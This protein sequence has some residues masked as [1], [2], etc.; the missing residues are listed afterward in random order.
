MSQNYTIVFNQLREFI[1]NISGLDISQVDLDSNFIELGLDSLMMVRLNQKILKE[2][3]IEMTMLQF[4]EDTNTL[5]KIIHFLAQ[6]MPTHEAQLNNQFDKQPIHAPQPVIPVH[7]PKIPHTAIEALMFNQMQ[8]MSQLMSQQL[9]LL[10]H[11]SVKEK[12][13]PTIS[14]KQPKPQGMANVNLR[15]MKLEPDPLTSQQQQFLETFINRYIQRSKQSRAFIQ[16]YRPFLSDW[17]NSLGFRLSLKEIMYPVVGPKSEGSKFWDVDGN[18]YIDIACG[19]GVSFLGNRPPFVIQ[20]IEKQLHEGFELGPQSHVVGEV[21]Q[22]VCELTGAE[23][24]AFCN[25]GSESVMF[26]IRIARAYTGKKLIVLFSGSYHG[27]SD[28]VLAAPGEDGKNIPAAPGTTDGMVQDV[29]IL[30]YGVPESLEIIQSHAHELAAVLVEPVQSRRPGFQPKE[31]LHDLRNI[32]QNK[33]IVLIF[34]EMITGFRIHPGGAQAWFGIKADLATYGKIVAGGMPIGVVAGKAQYMNLIDGGMWQFNDHSHPQ[35]E[36]I[37][38]AGTFC[39]HPLT[40]AAAKAALSFLK[41]QGPDLQN[42]V[43]KRTTYFAQTLN[44]FFEQNNV[45][46][47]IEYFGSLFRFESFG[48]YHQLLQPIEMDI[49]FYLLMEKGIYTWE[50]RVCFFSIAHTDDDIELIIAKVKETINDM[51]TGGFSL[52]GSLKEKKIAKDQPVHYPIHEAQKQLWFLARLNENAIPAYV[53]SLALELSGSLNHE[54][55]Q[56]AVQC[57]VDR[58]DSLR[59]IFEN[60]GE[61]QIVLPYVKV[62]IPLVDMSDQ[63]ALC[64]DDIAKWRSDHQ[65]IH[66]NLE[67]GPLFQF[68]FFKIEAEKYILVADFHHTVADGYSLLVLLKDLCQIYSAL[69]ENK[70]IAFPLPLQYSDFMDWQQSYF[71]SEKF[72]TDE[73]FWLSQFPNGLPTVDFPSDYPRPNSFTFHGARY[74]V[75]CDSQ[76]YKN[77]QALGLKRRCTSFMTMLAAYTLLLHRI[78]G[79]DEVIIGFPG[80]GRFFEGSEKLTGYCAHMVPFYSQLDYTQSFHDYLD[81]VRQRLL[82]VYDHQQYPFSSLIRKLNLPQ[83]M[84]RGAAISFEFNLDRFTQFPNMHGL[85]VTPYD[86]G[87]QYAKYDLILDVLDIGND[88]LLKFEYASDCFSENRIQ[89]LAGHYLSLLNA[90][91]DNPD[92]PVGSVSLLSEQQR[93]Q[94]LVEWNQTHRDI[95]FHKCFHELFENQVRQTPNVIAAVDHLTSI[96]YQDLNNRANGL[97][98]MLIEQNIGP[99]GLVAILA[100]R[101]IDFLIAILGVFKAGGAYIP[102]DPLHPSQRIY[103]V[104]KESQTSLVLAEKSFIAILTD[105]MSSLNDKPR[106]FILDEVLK[107]KHSENNPP[108]RCT[109]DHLA[110]VIYTSGSTGVPKGAMVEHKGM[111]NHLFAKVFELQLTSKDVVAQNASQCFDISVWQFLS[112]LLVGGKTHICSNDISHDPVLLLDQV[113]NH[114][115]TILEL[116]PSLLRMILDEIDSVGEKRPDLSGLRWLVP[117]GEALPPKLCAQWLTHYP[118]IPVLNAYGPTEC[119]DDVSHF[120]I[121]TP[122]GPKTTQIPIG[123][124]IINMQLYILDARLQPVPVGVVGELYVGGIGVGRGYLNNPKKTAEAFLKNPFSSDPNARLYKTG[125]LARF[126]TDGNIEF[127]GRIDHQVKVR[128]FRIELGEIE[129]VLCQHPQIR[130]TVVLARED[131]PGDQRLVA[132]VVPHSALQ[133]DTDIKSHE[134][135]TFLSEN[136]PEYMVPSHYIW[137]TEFKLTSNGKIDRKALPKPDNQDL[138]SD[139]PYHAPKNDIEK[140]LVLIWEDVLKRDKIGTRDNYFSLGGD[141][142]KSIQIVSRL[143]LA[144]LNLPIRDIF[145]YPTIA[146]LALRVTAIDRQIDQGIVTGNVP[147]TAI[148]TWFFQ[149]LG[150]QKNHYNQ[151]ICLDSKH[152]LQKHAVQAALES[153]QMH[154]DA[155]RMTFLTH[156]EGVGVVHG[157]DYPFAFDDIDLTNTQN[158]LAAYEKHANQLQASINFNHGPLMKSMLFHLP[159]RDRLLIVVHHLVMD[160]VSWQILLQDFFMAYENIVANTP[161]QLPLKTDS[162]KRWAE[163]IQ[164]FANSNAIMTEKP[165]WT[166]LDHIHVNPLPIDAS[167]TNSYQDLASESIVFSK[168]DTNCLLYHVNH[169]YNTEINDILLVSL[170]RTFHLWHGDKRTAIM[171]EGHGRENLFEQIDITR[172]IGWFTSEFPVILDLTSEDTGIQ[173]KTIKEMIRQIPNKGI[174]YGILKYLTRTEPVSFQLRPQ[175]AFNYLGQ[176]DDIANPLVELLP[177]ADKESISPELSRPYD[178]DIECMIIKGQL[179]VI[180]NY[181]KHHLNPDIANWL[182]SNFDTELRTIMDHCKNK[183]YSE[184]TPS[185]LTYSRLSLDELD[186]IISTLGI[187]K[188]NLQDMYSLSHMQEGMLFHK[189]YHQD[190]V[191]YFEQFS[192]TITGDLMI[193]L[194]EDTWNMLMKRYDILRTVFA[195]KGIPNPLQ[196]VLKEHP[197]EFMFH[198]IRELEKDPNAYVQ[199]FKQHDRLKGFD[200]SKDVLT[201]LS[202]FQVSDIH[203]HVVWSYHHIIMDGWCLG[204]LVKELLSSYQALQ[205]GHAPVLKPPMQYKT[206]IQWLQNQDSNKSK[207]FWENYLYGYT[208][209]ASLPKTPHH[210]DHDNEQSQITGSL[211]SEQ[212]TKRLHDFAVEAQV[213]P[214]SVI[215]TV[216]G[217]LL[218]HYNGVDD[219]VFGIAVSGRPTDIPEVEDIVGLFLNTVPLRVKA[220]KSQRFIDLVQT[221]QSDNLAS[222]PHHYYS[223]A[224]IQTHSELKQDLLDHVFIFQNFPLSEALY[225]LEQEF[226]LNFMMDD[227]DIFEQTSYDLSIEINPGEQL[228]IDLRYNTSLFQASYIKTISEQVVNTIERIIDNPDLTVGAIQKGFMTNEESREQAN[229]IATAMNIDEE[230]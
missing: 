35:G 212:Y 7:Q 182:L 9:D 6:H 122:P 223:L 203:Y 180:I 65:T 193:G 1:T 91:V 127:L 195:Y 137:M 58:H 79:S 99:D 125:D 62:E 179:Q 155:L 117:T 57:V 77:I 80:A 134:L 142:I 131:E 87:I 116:V 48:K 133:N 72:K 140:K 113:V 103:Q 169:A 220:M 23:R 166:S 205:M 96:T 64:A 123:R 209:L 165:Y 15:G 81:F 186:N 42:Q 39:K 187:E 27:N 145:L 224:D 90:L 154:H 108:I 219:V 174:G 56:K 146:E 147:L 4:Y 101:S 88:I 102:L 26:A 71:Q 121:S 92:M 78:T 150:L 132:Y 14:K 104:L 106:L 21:A 95:P 129:A 197:I 75:T 82:S 46:I 158:P 13:Q 50:K 45:A 44:Q 160:G 126:Q 120:R 25:T 199:Q 105:A 66:M 188:N 159:K 175:I 118:L 178:I 16:Q 201:R 2:F 38:F 161:I 24:A 198:D 189:L 181:N 32:T 112:A 29:L 206:Y 139:T 110:Y 68:T 211:L 49:F 162:F 37:F 221:V 43:N 204:I 107:Q 109:P 194:F 67:T 55:F 70:S 207:E 100:E 124:P 86:L 185:D 217:I 226:K 144:H 111:L 98:H 215:Q 17:I 74:Q 218:A 214:N 59:T 153:I 130:E 157:L 40:M 47:R 93:H 208:H 85:Q 167:P 10:K 136:L 34:D 216:W 210:V 148:Q 69:C 11:H 22:L 51:R 54:R 228:G 173:I 164:D 171:M 172:T 30:N 163:H 128:G 61:T 196:I 152:P 202:I 8:A 114:G 63:H 149:T 89:R 5:N 76:L 141:S 227:L 229:F 53:E 73:A 176:M 191:A 115:V 3:G 200:L 97:A 230:F 31:F 225:G 222:E 143:K 28:A 119:S 170:A 183:A 83:D 184:L 177:I 33:N 138:K 12:Q 135:R 18:E 60:N 151:A 190:S 36:M 213:T 19:Y 84:S 41:E 94:L 52:E 168:D 156:Q 192:F 20:A